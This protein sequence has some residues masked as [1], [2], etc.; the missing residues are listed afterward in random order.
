[1][2]DENGDSTKEDDLTCAIRGEAAE[3]RPDDTDEKNKESRSRFLSLTACL[4]ITYFSCVRS[5]L[6][7]F[8]IFYVCGCCLAK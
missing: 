7:V 5:C 3:Q 4:H 1:M 6:S 2:D 8:T